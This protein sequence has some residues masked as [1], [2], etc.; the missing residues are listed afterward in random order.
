MPFLRR[1]IRKSDTGRLKSIKQSSDTIMASSVNGTSKPS[2]RKS[3]SVEYG[4]K[5]RKRTLIADAEFD[6]IHHDEI[7]E[8]REQIKQDGEAIEECTYTILVTL[9]DKQSTSVLNLINT[10]NRD[11]LKVQ[12]METRPAV[13]SPTSKESPMGMWNA[14][15]WNTICNSFTNCYIRS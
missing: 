6:R 10:F 15:F 8:K 3:Y 11:G 9:K 13:A 5:P 1:L 12:H 14:F 7:Q 2:F 4:Y